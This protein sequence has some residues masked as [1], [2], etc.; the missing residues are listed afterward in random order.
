MAARA[1]DIAE[2]LHP[3]P[4]SARFTVC[5]SSAQEHSKKSRMA[6]IWSASLQQCLAARRFGTVP[7]F[8]HAENL[9]LNKVVATITK[10]LFEK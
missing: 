8:L 1:T 9:A 7:I 6:D 4:K 2:W 10:R 5:P 3:T